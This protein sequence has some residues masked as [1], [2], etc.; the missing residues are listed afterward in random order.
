MSFKK[1]DI[2]W[3]QQRTQ[4]P[5]KLRHPAVVWDVNEVIGDTVFLGV[6][7]TSAPPSVRHDNILMQDSHFCKG[8]KVEY[9]TTYFVNQIFEKIPIWGPFEKVGQLTPEG[10]E[11]IEGRISKAPAQPF[12]RYVQP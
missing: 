10:I 4:D 7:L 12:D 9:K 1:G 11:F 6:M 5:T 2:I 8:F 3:P